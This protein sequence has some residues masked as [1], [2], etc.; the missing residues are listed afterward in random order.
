MTSNASTRAELEKRRAE[1]EKRIA[2]LQQDTRDE[3]ERTE[4]GLEDVAHLSENSEVRTDLI[5]QA[6]NELEEI[7]R[8]FATLAPDTD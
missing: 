7:N 3:T 5:N 1:L 4:E 2:K 8:S 6:L